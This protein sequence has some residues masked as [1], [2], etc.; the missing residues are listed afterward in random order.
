MVRDA[1]QSQISHHHIHISATGIAIAEDHLNRRSAGRGGGRLHHIDYGQ[2]VSVRFA[3]INTGLGAP[4]TASVF[5]LHP[6]RRGGGVVVLVDDMKISATGV[7]KESGVENTD[8]A[9][10]AGHSGKR[11]PGGIIVSVLVLAQ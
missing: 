9:S 4:S 11:C 1:R 5:R 7:I 8:G 3:V 10:G 6:N 2:G